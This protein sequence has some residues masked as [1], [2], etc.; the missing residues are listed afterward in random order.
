MPHLAE[1][2]RRFER[3]ARQIPPDALGGVD[4]PL[5]Q[6]TQQP[7]ARLLGYYTAEGCRVALESY[8]LLDTL[9]GRGYGHFDVR[10]ELEEYRH[11]I[12]VTA[13]DE[14]ICVCHLRRARGATDP[15]IAAFQRD[16]LPDLLFVEWLSLTDPRAQFSTERPLL[17]GQD[18]PGSGIGEAVFLLLFMSARRLR[19]HGVL[20]VPE[21]FHNAVMYREGARFIDPLFE[22]RFR[23]VVAL[24]GEHSLAEVSWAMHEGRIIDAA[25]ETV[26]VWQPREQLGI[27]DERL[28]A[29][30][31]LSAWRRA[32]DEARTA[33]RPRIVPKRSP[34]TDDPA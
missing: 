21:H 3:I 15:C 23:A 32:R 30:F 1:L 27:L 7:D 33:C 26:M 14:L 18:R 16:F 5:L 8:G 25:D 4:D 22:G 12:R 31:E 20:E 13:D 34:T 9:R 11:T 19:L 28:E 6:L 17:P 2:R 29:Y 24:L 10:L